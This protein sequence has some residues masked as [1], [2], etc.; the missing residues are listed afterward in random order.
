MLHLELQNNGNAAITLL[1][2]ANH[3]AGVGQDIVSLNF[4]ANNEW[5]TTKDGV[6]AQIRCENGNGSYADRG[7]LVFCCWL[8]W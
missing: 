7:Q 6:Y 1:S 2:S 5:S 3:S 8:Q 4:A